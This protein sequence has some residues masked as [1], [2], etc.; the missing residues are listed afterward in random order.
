MKTIFPYGLDAPP[1]VRNLVLASVACLALVVVGKVDLFGVQIDG[2]QWPALGFA[3]GAGAMAWSSAVGKLRRRDRLLDKLTWT[4]TEQVLDLGCGR[5]LMAIGAAKRLSTGHVTGIDLW[6]A[7]DLSGNDGA[8]VL[9]NAVCEGVYGRV[10]V[11]TADMRELPFE[12][13]SIDVVVSATAIHNIYD[14]AGRDKA[15]DEIARVLRP[16]GRVVIYDIRH[17]AQYARRLADH[18]FAVGQL[19]CGISGWFWRIVAFGTLNP[20]SLVAHKP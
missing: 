1:V 11:Q 15:I 9:V 7:E 20:G 16:G 4:G 5:G 2:F 19:G 17:T 6:Q 12:A 14:V 10:T 13:N 18:G 8:A 3:I